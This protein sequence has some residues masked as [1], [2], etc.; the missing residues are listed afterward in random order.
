MGKAYS[1]PVGLG[2]VP[3][4]ISFV[5]SGALEVFTQRLVEQ[6]APEKVILFGFPQDQSAAAVRQSLS[7]LQT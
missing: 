1:A 2:P 4:P 5:T 3:D 7:F 6:L